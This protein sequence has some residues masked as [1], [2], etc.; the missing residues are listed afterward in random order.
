M[1]GDD[2]DP[3]KHKVQDFDALVTKFNDIQAA[4]TS[5]LTGDSER[6]EAEEYQLMAEED[7]Q[8][9]CSNLA[10]WV[11]QMEAVS[12]V[13]TVDNSLSENLGLPVTT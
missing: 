2:L 11:A 1:S 5:T 3:V 6:F 8:N 9:F 10:S 4:Y 12:P 13:D 7:V